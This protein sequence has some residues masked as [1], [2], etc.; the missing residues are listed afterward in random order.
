L[1]LI[2]EGWEMSSREIGGLLPDSSKAFST[3]TAGLSSRGSDDVA[4]AATVCIVIV[5]CRTQ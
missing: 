5:V 3:L 2:S 4:E 1:T